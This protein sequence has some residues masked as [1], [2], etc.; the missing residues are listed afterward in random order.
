[1]QECRC[2]G[3]PSVELCFRKQVIVEQY[4]SLH[5][6][7]FLEPNLRI[8]PLPGAKPVLLAYLGVSLC[9]LCWSAVIVVFLKMMNNNQQE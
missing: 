5:Q 3:E 1:M 2:L 4:C 7:L 9:V 8:N 6:S